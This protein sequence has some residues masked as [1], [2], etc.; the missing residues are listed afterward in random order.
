M[1]DI[2]KLYLGIYES[3]NFKIDLA[4]EIFKTCQ[5][6]INIR[7]ILHKFELS[8]FRAI[9]TGKKSLIDRGI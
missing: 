4:K 8:I 9:I 2:E 7:N 6:Q 3:W 5:N 1:S